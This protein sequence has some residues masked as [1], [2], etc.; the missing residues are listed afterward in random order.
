[1]QPASELF[2]S[3]ISL[4]SSEKTTSTNTNRQGEE[5][6]KQDAELL[7]IISTLVLREATLSSL[8]LHSDVDKSCGTL[9]K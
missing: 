6:K 3:V 8:T 9:G 4:L 2:L 1:M 7:K 5:Q